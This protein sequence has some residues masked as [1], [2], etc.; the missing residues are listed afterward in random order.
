MNPQ[1]I[2]LAVMASEGTATAAYLHAF[3]KSGMQPA[4]ILDLRLV[5]R[6]RPTELAVRLLGKRITW[7]LIHLLRSFQLRRGYMKSLANIIMEH[8]PDGPDF[9]VP[10]DYTRYTGQ[11]DRLYSLGLDDPA[12]QLYFEQ[13]PQATWLYSASGIMPETL[14]GM[15]GKFFI[16]LH[17]G[18]VPEVRGGDCLLWSRA[19]R[20]KPGMSCFYMNAGIDTGDIIATQEFAPLQFETA[21][22]KFTPDQMY[23]AVMAFY[24]VLLRG[25]M[26]K[27]LLQK[28]GLTADY[29]KLPSRR[30]DPETGR[31]F[32]T[33]HRALRARILEKMF[34]T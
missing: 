25:E 31:T 20:G 8:F 10:I 3:E 7:Y 34:F 21:E 29:A 14:L 30:Q 28:F 17:P 1:P 23:E 22:A 32:F 15:P 27:G 12:L 9:F 18:V 4:R 13:T 2:N 19:V 16:H 5:P 24:D 26:L 6:Y 11:V 33:M